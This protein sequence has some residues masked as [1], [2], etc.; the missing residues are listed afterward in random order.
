MQACIWN[1]TLAS[2]ASTK[3]GM[4]GW[5]LS[6]C[7]C[8]I[9][10]CIFL[11]FPFLSEGTELYFYFILLSLYTTHLIIKQLWAFI[12]FYRGKNIADFLPTV[13]ITL[14]KSEI[15]PPFRDKIILNKYIFWQ[16]KMDHKSCPLWS[17]MLKSKVVSTLLTSV[18]VP[19]ASISLRRNRSSLTISFLDFVV[20]DSFIGGTLCEGGEQHNS[21]SMIILNSN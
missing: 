19:Y 6:D 12:I 7:L 14:Q 5:M 21:D 13:K 3:Y 10:D 4:C 16:H 15:V 1:D 8:V 9:K 17:W 11:Q 20:D 18:S 2:C